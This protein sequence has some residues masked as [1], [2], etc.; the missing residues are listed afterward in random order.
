MTI[1]AY[2]AKDN[3]IYVDTKQSWDDGLQLYGTKVLK[4]DNGKGAYSGV[5]GGDLMIR[6]ALDKLQADPGP[7]F[8]LLDE[9]LAKRLEQCCAF[10]RT[11]S[12]D[13]YYVEVEARAMIIAP[14]GTVDFAAGSGA[15]MFRMMRLTGADFFTALRTVIKCV[16]TCGGH[17]E[18]L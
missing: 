7:N 8:L 9:S 11:P 15:T 4:L 2:H 16:P 18:R 10:V 17:I 14:A 3:D 5:F 1:I 6:M 12:G 13:V